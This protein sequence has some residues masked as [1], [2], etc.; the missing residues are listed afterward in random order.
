MAT[1]TRPQPSSPVR[2]ILEQLDELEALMQRMLALPVNQLEGEAG[3]VAD[4]STDPTPPLAR[5]RDLGRATPGPTPTGPGLRQAP[6][7]AVR[8]PNNNVPAPALPPGTVRSRTDNADGQAGGPQA[9]PPA[10]RTSETFSNPWSTDAERQA[11]QRPEELAGFR[12]RPL[13]W[14]NQ[15]FDRCTSRLGPL[16]PGVRGPRGRAVI[17]WAGLLLLAAAL[18]WAVLDWTGWL[19]AAPGSWI[20]G[21]PSLDQPS[22]TR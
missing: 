13:M 9:L 21:K 6:E 1:P 8:L 7:E 20:E 15:A 12:F 11:S 18:T 2:P 3:T 16:G 14:V 17:G 4:T 22:A 5:S 10:R 19:P